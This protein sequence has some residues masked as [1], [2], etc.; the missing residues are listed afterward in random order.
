MRLRIRPIFGSTFTESRSLEEVQRHAH[1]T[2]RATAPRAL[3]YLGDATRSR[4]A[5][6]A[7]YLKFRSR[8]DA[9]FRRVQQL[10]GAA[11]LLDRS[12]R[13]FGRKLTMVGVHPDGST[14]TLEGLAMQSILN[15][16]ADGS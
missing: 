5:P 9:G 3:D 8:L 2:R 15:L 6:Q 11:E 12:D 16:G 13:R 14:L 7:K 4:N 10:D 1:G